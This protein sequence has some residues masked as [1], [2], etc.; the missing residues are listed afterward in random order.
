M[1]A[2]VDGWMNGDCPAKIGQTWGQFPGF[3]WQPAQHLTASP[4][5]WHARAD[6]NASAYTPTPELGPGRPTQGL[7][8]RRGL[9]NVVPGA[10]PQHSPVATRDPTQVPSPDTMA[11]SMTPLV[12]SGLS[13][14][15]GTRAHARLPRIV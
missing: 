3:S 15:R 13:E 1:G 4:L 9:P 12:S 5:P 2:D 11:S 14:F 7:V 10:G 6:V 8:T